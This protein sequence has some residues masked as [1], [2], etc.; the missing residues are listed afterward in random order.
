MHF[1]IDMLSSV[2]RPLLKA[3][4]EKGGSLKDNDFAK[5]LAEHF[6][7]VQTIP[8]F[9]EL[10][11]IL[12]KNDLPETLN[13]PLKNKSADRRI[14]HLYL[15]NVR[16]YCPSLNKE[17]SVDFY[18]LDLSL[19]DKAASSILLGPNGT[20]KTSLYSSL[21]YLYQGYSEIAASHG[22]ELK[23]IDNFFRSIGSPIDSVQ[24]DAQLVKEEDI[25]ENR[26]Q[27]YELPAAFCSECDYFEISRNWKGINHYIAR[28]LGYGELLETIESVSSLTNLLRNAFEYKENKANIESADLIV[29]NA[30]KY[31]IEEVNKA[32]KDLIS[33]HQ[34]AESIKKIFD[35]EKKNKYTKEIDEFLL[36]DKKKTIPSSKLTEVEA[37]CTSLKNIWKERLQDFTKIAGS[38]FD[39]MM[40]EYLFKD[41]ES[42]S[43]EIKKDVFQLNIEVKGNNQT[44]NKSPITY[45]NTF[46]LK[47][48]CVA[49]K[50]SL[51]CCAKKLYKINMPFVID[52]IFDSSDFYHRSN[53]GS[54]IANMVASHDKAMQSK[55]KMKYDLQLIFFTQDNIIAE[56]VYRGLADYLY[57]NSQEEMSEVKFGRLFRPCDAKTPNNDEDNNKR[58][59]H[60]SDAKLKEKDLKVIKIVDYYT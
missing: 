28:Q 8:N 43:L 30:S 33:L 46:R 26:L 14:K 37:T 7:S 53:I 5:R 40:T 44:E 32:K 4:K 12:Y 57:Q 35:K 27:G 19:E 42:L 15:K 34:K 23:Q 3:I 22:H 49:L 10:L 58:A 9:S 59:S 50:M 11:G 55:E 47:L 6:I 17:A 38:V 21:E 29:K 60:I 13:Y 25:I 24:I 54:F 36:D 39:E 48:F 31:K 18:S 45:L 41:T 56:N 1:A 2:I 51:F 20:G 16:Q 52:D